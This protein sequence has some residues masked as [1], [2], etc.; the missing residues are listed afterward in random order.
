MTA[1]I[2][3]SV[4]AAQSIQK[5]GRIWITEVHTDSL[6]AKYQ[7]NYLATDISKLAASLAANAV[8]ILN[9]L[10]NQEIQ[11]NINEIVMY[12]SKFVPTV[13]YSTVAANF[14]ELKAVWINFTQTQA[15]MIGDYLNQ[16]SA[17][18]LESVFGWSP[19]QTASIQSTYLVPYAAMAASIR[20]AAGVM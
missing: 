4:V 15:I 19:E 8:S 18:T 7:I 1:T 12:G 3:S 9:D 16:L 14:A 2:I 6:G 13:N 20:V 10:L 5:D 11:N 17:A